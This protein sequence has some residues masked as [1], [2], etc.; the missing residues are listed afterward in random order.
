MLACFILRPDG[1]G[2]QERGGEE[3][4]DGMAEV[5]PS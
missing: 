3:R 2:E 1:G 5:A 4:P